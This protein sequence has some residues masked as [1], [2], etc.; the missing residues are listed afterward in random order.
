MYRPPHVTGVYSVPLVLRT[1]PQVAPCTPSLTKC[2][3]SKPP[4][5]GP[6]TVVDVVELPITVEL[7]VVELPAP[8]VGHAPGAGASFAFRKLASFLLDTPPKRAQ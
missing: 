7:V 3:K 6:P 5:H 1:V 2:A 8:G 4:Q